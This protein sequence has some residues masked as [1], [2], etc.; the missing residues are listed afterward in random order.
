MKEIENN[1]KDILLTLLSPP[2]SNISPPELLA[3]NKLPGGLNR[4]II[5]NL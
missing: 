1:A 2:L 5:Y 3:N 4:E